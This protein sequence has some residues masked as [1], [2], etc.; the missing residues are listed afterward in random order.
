ML[1]L[2][3]CRDSNRKLENIR[4]ISIIGMLVKILER[5]IQ[6]CVEIYESLDEI[7]I[8][9][10]QV[11]FVKGLGCDV[12]IMRLRQRLYD[13]KFLRTKEEK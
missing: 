4:L 12:N 1:C 10:A 9:K 13:L 2:N 7:K 6:G 11:V 8:C 5:V 3:K